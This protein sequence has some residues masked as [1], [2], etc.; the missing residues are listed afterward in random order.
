MNKAKTI[1]LSSSLLFL[2]TACKKNTDTEQGSNTVIY[3]REYMNHFEI[4]VASMLPSETFIIGDV[5]VYQDA[6]GQVTSSALSG[7]TNGKSNWIKDVVISNLKL[8]EHLEIGLVNDNSNLNSNLVN[9]QLF[10]T[11]FPFDN[12]GEKKI[13]LANF[14]EYSKSEEKVVLQ[15][16][17]K[18]LTTLFKDQI[19]GGKLELV[20]K[21][22]QTPHNVGNMRLWYSIPFDY[23]Y[24]YAS[25]KAEKKE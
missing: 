10:F 21:F 14:I 15:S 12:S 2:L 6:L 4:E 25:K 20:F 8:S 9:C 3:E 13:L 5:N 23:V 18:D 11:Y 19:L 22:A 24:T 7:K 1:I 17:G 16:V